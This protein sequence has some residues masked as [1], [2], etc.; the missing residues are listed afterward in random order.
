MLWQ[1][2][3]SGGVGG[4]LIEV[5]F[6][7]LYSL[8]NGNI[9]LTCQTSLWMVLVYGTARCLFD[10]LCVTLHYNRFTMACIY[11]PLIY[12]QEFIWGLLFL[13]VLKKR[14]WDYGLS[15]WS[16]MG[17]IN[18]RYLPAWFLLALFF[19]KINYFLHTL[20]RLVFANL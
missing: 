3:L 7:G 6:T 8:L 20:E 12:F 14:L 13:K 2:W 1:T 11:T 17:L 9:K 5:V 19:D 15:H 4:L 16:P 18:F 10:Y